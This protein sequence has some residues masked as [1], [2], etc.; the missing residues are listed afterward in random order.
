MKSRRVEP[1]TNTLY[2]LSGSRLERKAA[3]RQSAPHP[4][5]AAATPVETARAEVNAASFMT[6]MAGPT[7][8]GIHVIGS[9]A[10][11]VGGLIKAVA[12]TQ[13]W[14]SWGFWM[15]ALVS[16]AAS[17]C[18]ESSTQLVGAGNTTAIVD[19]PQ[20]VN[21]SPDN[22][23]AVCDPF[24][25]PNHPGAGYDHGIVA[26][27]A[28]L[29]DDQPRY[30]QVQDYQLNAH[31]IDATLFFGM[32]DIPTR[33]FDRGFY[34]LS[35]E[36][37][38]NHR[39]DT[40][41]EYFTL[42]FESVI[43]LHSSNAAAKYQFGILSDD[44]A[45]LDV[46]TGTGFRRLV[47]NNGTHPTKFAC[48]AEAIDMNYM[49]ELPI[50]VDYYQGPRYHISMML[51]WREWKEDGTFSP[52]DPECGRSGNSRFFNSTVTP[53]TPQTAYQNMVAR[54]WQPVPAVNYFL[55]QSI[56]SNPCQAAATPTPTPAAVAT[57]ISSANPSAAITNQ[58][59]ITFA[60]TSNAVGATFECSL[61]S[62]AFTG[63]VSPITYSAL[64]SG[65]HNFAVRATYLGV[66]DTTGASHSWTI[67]ATIPVLVNSS[68][69][70]T[71]N[72]A[73]I[74]WTTNELS[75]TG[76]LWGLGTDTSQVIA[77]D[78]NFVTSH[79]LSLSGLAPD[80]VYSYRLISRDQAG[81]LYTSPRR[82]FRTD[83]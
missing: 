81:N 11:K 10:A 30:T 51:L 6:A 66:Q 15:L 38:T 32:L 68:V 75:T 67:D 65:L 23:N 42:H 45:T 58:T 14:S 17:G 22:S 18:N 1:V 2:E 78:S 33:P 83:P 54:G 20:D 28:Y 50:K 59:S 57:S 49:T 63:C 82:V 44:G 34:T 53:P 69:A 4:A 25:D 60:F 36:L 76:L 13:S 80:T 3:E 26:N 16:I 7:P 19:T 43:K 21:A 70:V 41:Y 9:I 48:A 47:D 40:L 61:D 64:A 12:K 24:G 8:D 71:S 5:S 55:P 46:D 79:A 29:S 73:V 52:A 27:I 31:P 35:G 72:S 56:R 77:E 74:N 62:A 37:L 39:G